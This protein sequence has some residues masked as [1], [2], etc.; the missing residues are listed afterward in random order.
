ME[1]NGIKIDKR[2]V[3]IELSLMP[4]GTNKLSSL[5][6]NLYTETSSHDMW[7]SILEQRLMGLASS[8]TGSL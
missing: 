5:G 6:M 3:L 1:D 2:M 4:T 7:H 8:E